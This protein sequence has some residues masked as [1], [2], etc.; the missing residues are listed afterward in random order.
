MEQVYIT[1]KK[2]E[3]INYSEKPLDKGEYESCTFTYCDFANTDLSNILFIECSFIN[4][5]LSLVKLTKTAFRDVTFK[6]CKMLGMLFNNCNDFGFS[7]QFENCQLNHSSF[8]KLKLKKTLFKNCSLEE[9]DFSESDL[10]ES[11][12]DGSQLKEARFEHTNLEKADL[13]TASSY[14][15]DPEINKIKKA[16]FSLSGVIGLLDKYDIQIT[17]G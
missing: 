11:K 5:N 17:H 12:F 6:D 9:V 10:T 2:F 4:C 16:K 1:D 7:V 13:R 8:F 14:S 3:K 15:I